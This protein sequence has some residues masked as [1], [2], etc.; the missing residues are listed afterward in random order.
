MRLFLDANVLIS[1]LNREYPDFMYSSR[2]LSLVDSPRYHVYTSP[3]CLAIAYYFAEKKSGQIRARKK[4]DLLAEKIKITHL[5]TLTVR[6]ALANQ[7]IHDFEDGLEYYSAIDSKC[8]CIVTA[9]ISD[10]Y[11]STIEV[12]TPAEFIIRHMQ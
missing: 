10:Y 11:F 6:K 5:N 1:V 9:N 7:A 3:L 4:I 2:I 8:E 12:V